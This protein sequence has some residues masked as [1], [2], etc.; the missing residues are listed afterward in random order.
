MEK[1]GHTTELS[2][3]PKSHQK[4][5][6]WTPAR[7]LEWAATIGPFTLRFVETL[8]VTKPHP[9]AGYRAAMGLRPLASEYGRERLEA[10]STRAIRFKLYRLGHVRSILTTQ[11]DQQPLPQLVVSAEPV[12]HDNIRGASYYSAGE[13]RDNAV[14]V[15]G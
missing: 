2:H 13:D 5:L 6:E 15:A 12:A 1:P 4:Y 7:L 14:E 9:E 8:L 10:A 11:L 3:R